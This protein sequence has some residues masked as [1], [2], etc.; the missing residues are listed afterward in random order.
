MATTPPALGTD[1]FKENADERKIYVPANSVGD[2]STDGTYK[3]KWSAYASAIEA[4]PVTATGD[5]GTN[6][7]YT[8]YGNGHLVISGTGA[9]ED[10]ERNNDT[11]WNGNNDGITSIVIES[12]VASI[13]NGAFQDCYNLTSVSIPAS[14]TSIGETAFLQCGTNATALTVTFAEGS[15]LATIGP[16]AFA[17]ANLTSI[18]IPN[19]V[20]SIGNS[21]FKECRNLT[22]VSIPASVT[23]LG[24]EAFSKSGTNAA[25]LT[26]TFAEGTSPM[27]IGI[28]A[29]AVSNLTSISIP[30]RVTSIDGYAFDRCS[31]LA[32]ITLN[33]NPTIGDDAF[34]GI[35]DGAT[36]KMNLTANS[37]DGAYWM[38]FYNENYGFTADTNT[39]IYKAKVND[40]KTAV[41]LTEVADIPANNAAVLK[42][43]NAAIT[44]TLASSTSGDYTDNELKGAASATVV[45]AGD[46]IYCLSNET[47]REGGLTPRG[48]G[49]Y[50]YTGTIPV[51]RAYLVVTP[52][53]SR[54]FLGFGDDDD[55]TA[56][57]NG[58][59]KIDNS[60]GTIYDLSGR[61]V[62]GHP[63][64]G[65]YVK[66][67]KLV[68]IK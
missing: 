61:I 13:D 28:G 54:G 18:T 26:V 56:I 48:V 25:A 46:N 30:N 21:A 5:C 22:S 16:G 55:A 32:T 62:T 53:T 12:R 37:G 38:T 2:T 34:L 6:C 23:S 41:V 7:T 39:K 57:D 42:S 33:S 10:Y 1:A 59:W 9:M 31:N 63:R 66:N 47:T 64:K 35:K 67:G 51:N 43:S 36:V 15:T 24:E 8:L 40:G 14:V 20:T 45:A 52:T 68:V 44:M 19:R 17:E 11:G 4:F 29:F 65:I 58:K 27:T 3:H 50:T 60:D 49:F